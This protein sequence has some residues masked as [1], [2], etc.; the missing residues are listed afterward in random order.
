MDYGVR[1]E[2]ARKGTLLGAGLGVML[3]ITG[4][5]GYLI[6]GDWS[7]WNVLVL[8]LGAVGYV[9]LFPLVYGFLAL[10]RVRVRLNAVEHVFLG[11]FVLQKR[12]LSGYVR[13]EMAAT[14]SRVIFADGRRIPLVWMQVDEVCRM[15]SDLRAGAITAKAAEL[16]G[17]DSPPRPVR[18]APQWLS[19]QDGAVKNVAETLL[20]EQKFDHLGILADAL[21]DA[22]CT[23]EVLLAH[24]RRPGPHVCGCW[25]IELFARK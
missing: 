3:L 7:A 15:E 13:T 20:G 8:L 14:G 11:Y 5:L 9:L 16:A 19:W 21:E 17:C 10:F 24:L 1:W 18:L 12:P 6:E 2:H 22:G 25:A 4:L 23:D